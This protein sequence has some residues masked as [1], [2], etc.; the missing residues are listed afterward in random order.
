[1]TEVKV[2]KKTPISAYILAILGVIY[3]IAPLDIVPDI[4]FLGWLDDFFILAATFLNLFEKQTGQSNT[5]L[6]SV[7]KVTKWVA[8]GIGVIVVLLLLVFGALIANLVT[9]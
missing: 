6:S 4:P 1:M 7:F 2:K 5:A 9:K 3:A 8:I